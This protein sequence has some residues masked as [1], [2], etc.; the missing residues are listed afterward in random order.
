MSRVAS[1]AYLKCCRRARARGAFVTVSQ[2]AR[3]IAP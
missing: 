2:R 3:R 1:R